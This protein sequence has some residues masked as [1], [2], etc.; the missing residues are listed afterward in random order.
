MLRAYLPQAN[1]DEELSYVNKGGPIGA[2]AVGILAVDGLKTPAI[3]GVV[4]SPST[5]DFPVLYNIVKETAEWKVLNLKAEGD[6][7]SARVRDDL[8][9]GAKELENRGVRA[10]SGGCGF[11]VNFQKDV[12][13]AV[14]IPVFL[15]SLSQLPLIRQGLKPGQKVGI[16]TAASDF[17][18]PKNFEQIDVHDLSDVVIV[19][20]ED[21]GEFKNLRSTTQ[22]GRVNPYKVARDMAKLA[23]EF[24]AD[25]PDIS[26]LLLECSSLPP[27]SWEI[28][29]AV[30]LPVFDYYTLIE[31]VYKAV[32]RKPFGGIY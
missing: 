30:N 28:Q 5:W 3:P 14:D 4:H 16:I 2:C 27:Y 15:S 24:V 18:G 7:F 12:A 17:L 13:A 20:C 19:G 11:L 10:I 25:N 23:T 9:A 6:Q 31:W 26:M 8:I 29:N 32:V 1:I 22:T 21:Y